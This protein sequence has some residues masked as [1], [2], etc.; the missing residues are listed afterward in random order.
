[1]PD[2]YTQANQIKQL[3]ESAQHIVVLQADNPDADSVGSALALEQILHE[4]GKEP[5]LYCGIDIPTYLRYLTGW[6]RVDNQLPP[7][8]D[9]SIIVDASTLS[10]FEKLIQSGAQGWISSKP[11]I[12]LDHHGKVSNLI[13]FATVTIN[14]ATAS[15]TGELIY[16][17]SE[18]LAWPLGTLAQEFIMTAILGDT[19]GLSN[20]LASANTYRIMADMIENKVDRTKLEESRREYNKMPQSIFKYKAQ[21]INRT[22]FYADGRLAIVSVPQA[23]I[24]EFSPLYNPA[25]LI[26]A[27][28]LQTEGVGVAVVLKHY[29]DGKITAAIR[30]N[31]LFPIGADLADH[32]GGGGHAYA[33]GFKVQDE[34]PFDDIKSECIRTATELMDRTVKP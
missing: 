11:C 23:E 32:F 6:D 3:V 9:L 34:R 24:N 14:D 10:L 5:S 18:Q 13:P 4:L 25:P 27:D 22:E 28:M 26:Q 33:S 17:L 2:T 1:M 31:P 19:Q 30:C 16:R 29:S 7:K 21:L 8:F 15:S 12:V 20:S